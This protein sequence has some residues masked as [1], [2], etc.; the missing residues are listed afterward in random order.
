MCCCSTQP[1]QHFIEMWS[2]QQ[3]YFGHLRKALGWKEGAV[4]EFCD[5]LNRTVAIE[6]PLQHQEMSTSESF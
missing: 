5:L 2:K 4:H 1:K 3:G 6:L